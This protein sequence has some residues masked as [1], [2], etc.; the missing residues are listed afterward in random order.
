MITIDDL[1]AEELFRSLPERLRDH[2]RLILSQSTGLPDKAIDFDL[3]EK[4]RFQTMK[5]Y[6]KNICAEVDQDKQKQ[7][8]DNL[9]F[10]RLT[11]MTCGRCFE[12]LAALFY[13]CTEQIRENR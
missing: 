6:L 9:N 8:I 13:S 5:K 12:D 3:E 10:Y 7:F 4:V 11:F 1:N 2:I